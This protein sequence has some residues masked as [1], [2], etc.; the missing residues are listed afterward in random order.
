MKKYLLIYGT[1]NYTNAINSLIKSSQDFFDDHYVFGP[2]DI[3]QDFYNKNKLLNQ[4]HIVP[5][6]LS[7]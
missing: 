2:S 7:L 1:Q 3:D 5:N 4:H 6:V